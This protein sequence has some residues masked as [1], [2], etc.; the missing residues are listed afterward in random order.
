M[1]GFDDP[2][3]TPTR[4]ATSIVEWPDVRPGT[5]FNIVTVDEIFAGRE[6]TGWSVGNFHRN[7]VRKFR[8]ITQTRPFVGDPD[9]I[10]DTDILE[11]RRLPRPYSPYLSNWKNPNGYLGGTLPPDRLADLN[12]LAVET[13][14]A[15][16][17]PDGSDSWI[18]TVRY[19]TDIG[20]TPPDYRF[21][22]GGTQFNQHLTSPES[23]QFRPWLRAPVFEYGY[24]ESTVAKQWDRNG[25]PFL[26]T[27]GFPFTPAPTVEVAYPTL[28]MTRNEKTFT[29]DMVGY[30]SYAVNNA[31][32]MGYPAGCVQVMP[33]SAK[34]LY[35]GWQK[36]YR[37]PWR[38]RFKPEETVNLL[39]A[40][41]HRVTWQ[42]LFLNAGFYQKVAGKEVPI[43]MNGHRA[44]G[45]PHLLAADGTA[46]PVGGTPTFVEFSTY[47]SRDFSL[48][49][50][51]TMVP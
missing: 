46:L 24:Q 38:F 13:H 8:V 47:P 14:V 3:Y 42:P 33:P 29:P 31:T 51:S 48:L 2:P 22:Y 1:P 21:M 32:F 34:I 11:D 15:R 37:V 35:H 9:T 7:Y 5:T 26:N 36:Y 41:G 30:W 4:T 25:N 10:D 43:N 49:F 45:Q 40:A 39:G 23:P 19:S 27:A 12:A 6:G 17:F 20:E 16:E 28:T 44:S 18:V 50:S